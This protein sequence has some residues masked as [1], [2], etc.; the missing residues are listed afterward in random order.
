MRRIQ[1]RIDAVIASSL[2][3][4][5]QTTLGR[6]R[7]LEQLAAAQFPT[8]E[9]RTFELES[10]Q[11]SAD[12]ATISAAT[13]PHLVELGTE[14]QDARDEADFFI[15]EHGL[16]RPPPYKASLLNLAGWLGGAMLGEAAV[17]AP[18]Y[19]PAVGWIHAI[20]IAGLISVGVTAPALTLGLGVVAARHRLSGFY[21]FIGTSIAF[22]SLVVLVVVL[23]SGPHFRET[24]AQTPALVNGPR[25]LAE[26][27]WRSL[28]TRPLTPLGELAN[29]GLLSAA[30]VAATIVAWETFKTFGYIGWRALAIREQ[31]A[32]EAIQDAAEAARRE[33]RRNKRVQE[34]AIARKGAAAIRKR[35]RLNRL[36]A[37]DQVVISSRLKAVALVHIEA[38]YARS[39]LA[40]TQERLTHNSERMRK[41]PASQSGVFDRTNFNSQIEQSRKA[42][43]Q[44]VA[45]RPTAI[46]ALAETHTA[47]CQ[48]L[49]RAVEQALGCSRLQP[50]GPGLM[51]SN[52]WRT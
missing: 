35:R 6:H 10:S 30:A 50:E 23:F 39:L 37:L 19:Q 34:K 9:D 27:V 44:L 41:P 15:E 5:A 4:I 29:W 38:A 25:A 8:P 16:P 33:A 49:Q 51:R 42:Y 11:Y 26:A 46:T 45:A 13:A 21:R 14:Y 43:E 17:T 24:L 28:W 2:E 20:L 47:F 18:I 12:L 48:S 3:D 22:V 7:H 1:N 32:R 52:C 40:R 36:V 31:E